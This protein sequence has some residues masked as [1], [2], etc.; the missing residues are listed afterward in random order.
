MEVRAF[1]RKKN[2]AVDE[3]L[4]GA[5]F[6]APINFDHVAEELGLENARGQYEITE[7][8]C[9]LPLWLADR[10]DIYIKDVNV[11]YRMILELLEDY[12]ERALKG[13][14][15]EWFRNVEDFYR[16][17]ERVQRVRS[18]EIGEIDG[19]KYICNK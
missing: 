5:W 8:D 12:P 2:G 16:Q 13:I 4:K 9:E 19:I 15:N 14:I 7:I 18:L 6:T 10:D 1:I 17:R 3:E 11:V